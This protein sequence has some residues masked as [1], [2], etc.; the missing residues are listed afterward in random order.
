MVYWVALM[1]VFSYIQEL[2]EK[3]KCN[4]RNAFYTAICVFIANREVYMYTL[5]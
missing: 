5:T 1:I 2:V 3:Q 4:G